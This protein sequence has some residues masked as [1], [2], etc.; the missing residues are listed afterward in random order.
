MRSKHEQGNPMAR[1]DYVTEE[2]LPEEAKETFAKLAPLNIFKMMAHSGKMLGY[3]IRLGNYI[4]AKSE[5]DPVLRE[6]AILRVGYISKATYETHQ[7][8]RIGR[9]VGMSDALIAAVKTGPTADG[10]SDLEQL[11]MN[12]TDDV[13]TN[14]RAADATF[15]PLRKHLSNKEMQELTMTIGFYMMTSRFL[16][17]FDVDIE[18]KETNLNL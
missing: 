4:L 12:F 10:F 15:D 8:E 16:E 14:V 11:V 13:V 3:Y 1:I 18:E 9:D 5:L 2:T 6:I 7:H 17:T